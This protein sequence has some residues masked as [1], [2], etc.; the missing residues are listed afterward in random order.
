[1]L[2][3]A[4]LAQLS[5]AWKK[6]QNF[7]SV[8]RFINKTNFILSWVEHEKKFYNLGPCVTIKDSE[9]TAH[10][11]S[12]ARVLVYPSLDSPEAVEG[13]C[14]QWRPWS[15]CADAQANLSLR[16]SQ[17]SYC[18]FFRALIHMMWAGRHHFLQISGERMCTILFNRLE[19]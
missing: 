17:K 13:T 3:S 15:D 6:F 12:M 2:N 1:M 11:F 16:W 10:P 8:L 9:Q 4:E 19:D 18:R 5:W 14:E 7:N